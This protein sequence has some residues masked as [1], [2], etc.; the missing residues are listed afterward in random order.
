MTED[1]SPA[2]ESA[3]NELA[4]EVQKIEG[5]QP[6]G[7][8]SAETQHDG[9]AEAAADGGDAAE[10]EKESRS[11]LRREQRKAKVEGLI[12]ENQRLHDELARLRQEEQF[13]K[14]SEPTPAPKR[15]QF[16]DPDD[17]IAA[18][19]AWQV[20]Q[21]L[22]QRQ[23]QEAEARRRMVES[24]RAQVHQ[25]QVA[26]AM[27]AF[28]EQAAE[29]RAQYADFDQVVF[30]QGPNGPQISDAL[31][32]MILASDVSAQLAYRVASDKAL[33][34]S[35]SKMTAVNPVGAARELA[36]LE[37]QLSAPRARVETRAPEPITPVRGKGGA[38]ADPLKMSPAEYAAWRAKGGTFTL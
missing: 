13:T 5:T 32:Q 35:L 36:K 3:G 22:E 27:A 4:P 2:A 17:Y 24:Q 18:R 30:A 28:Q 20:Q 29:V 34:A 8:E 1:Q 26:E 16:D 11:R 38:Q 23:A 31:S 10:A 12:A 37:L 14:P 19:A 7:A 15:D 25:Q 33:A 9:G 21:A 6:A